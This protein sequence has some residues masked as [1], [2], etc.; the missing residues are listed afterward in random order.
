MAH[1]KR[2]PVDGKMKV[3]LINEKEQRLLPNGRYDCSVKILPGCSEMNF[4]LIISTNQE[5]DQTVSLSRVGI[6]DH[7]LKDMEFFKIS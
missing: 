1:L 4:D 3:I 6:N 5:G 7:F 2:E